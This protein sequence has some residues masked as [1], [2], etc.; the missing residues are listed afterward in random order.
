MHTSP[1]SRRTNSTCTRTIDTSPSDPT[2]SHLHHS[3]MARMVVVDRMVDRM[4]DRIVVNR[5]AMMGGSNLDSAG[6]S[7]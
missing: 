5:E 1:S 2:A 3:V 6:W 7:C 4:V